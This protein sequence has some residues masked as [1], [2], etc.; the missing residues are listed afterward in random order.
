MISL[1]IESTGVLILNVC[2]F[3]TIDSTTHWRP[4]VNINPVFLGLFGDVGIEL[5][6]ENSHN[7]VG[8]SWKTHGFEKTHDTGD[9]KEVQ[10][11][12]TDDDTV[13]TNV[14]EFDIFG[15]LIYKWM[16]S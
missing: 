10:N 9:W 4:P 12:S 8:L 1:P 15:K 3:G 7:A 5:I 6:R 2:E 11:V 14:M 13:K 16:R